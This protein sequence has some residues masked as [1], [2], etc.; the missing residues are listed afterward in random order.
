MREVSPEDAP[1][2]PY[3]WE[4]KRMKTERLNRKIMTRVLSEHEL[5]S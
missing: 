4:Y 5:V 1:V 2:M 3:E